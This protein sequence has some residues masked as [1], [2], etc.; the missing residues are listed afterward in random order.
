MQVSYA[1]CGVEIH[2]LYCLAFS[3][4]ISGLDF[5]YLEVSLMVLSILFTFLHLITHN[6]TLKQF[7]GKSKKKRN[8]TETTQVSRD[9]LWTNTLIRSPRCLHGV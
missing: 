2:P 5:K 9:D 3:F 7:P 6:I 1:I 8:G 4:Q